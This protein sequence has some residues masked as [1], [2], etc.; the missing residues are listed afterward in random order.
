MFLARNQIFGNLS[1][2]GLATPGLEDEKQ[3]SD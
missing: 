2:A 1:G 3:F